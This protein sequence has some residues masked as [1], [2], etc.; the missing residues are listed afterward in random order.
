MSGYWYKADRLITLTATDDPDAFL[1]VTY[2]N[3]GEVRAKGLE[4]EAQMRLWRGAGGSCEL[5]APGRRRSGDRRH[6]QPT[7]RA[8]WPRRA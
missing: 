4:L 3:E 2:V 7:R 1:G 8:T 6:A 5:R